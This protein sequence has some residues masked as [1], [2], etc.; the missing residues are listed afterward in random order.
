MSSQT[1]PPGA[2]EK[3]GSTRGWFLPLNF[4]LNWKYDLLIDLSLLF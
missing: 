2:G 4:A 1:A 3:E